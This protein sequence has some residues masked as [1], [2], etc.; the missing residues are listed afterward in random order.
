[1]IVK[2]KRVVVYVRTSMADQKFRNTA[3]CI[4]GLL[5]QKAGLK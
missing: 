3:I 4:K 1:M 2:G 5:R